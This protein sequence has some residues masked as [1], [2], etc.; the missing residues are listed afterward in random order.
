MQSQGLDDVPTPR[1]DF[2]HTHGPRAEDG[3]QRKCVSQMKAAARSTTTPIPQVYSEMA[4]QL[5]AEDLVAAS[6]LLPEASLS[7]S[8][9]RARRQQ[10]PALPQSLQD[11]Q[12][13]PDVFS[14]L[15][16]GE[17]RFLL[18][19]TLADN[20]GHLLFATD[21]ALRWL[22]E[23]N[24]WHMDGT[25]KSAPRLF[26]QLFTIQVVRGN[27]T[28]PCIYGLLPTK[29]KRCYKN[30]LR[31]VKDAVAERHLPL[32]PTSIMVDFEVGLI[33]AIQDEFPNAD[34][35]GCL[36]HFSQAVWRHI[37][38]LGLTQ[39]YKADGEFKS[40]CRQL[41]AL[42]FLPEGDV[43][44]AY[45]FIEQ[46]AID[47]DIDD[48]DDLFAYYQEQWMTG[49]ISIATWNC[50]G[51]DIR[52]NNAVE[53]FHHRFNRVIG[54]NHPNTWI[55]IERLQQEE[56]RTQHII[57]QMDQGLRLRSGRRRYTQINERI[58]LLEQRRANEELD[59]YDFLV[60][61]GNLLHF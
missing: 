10:Y 21:E 57:S 61:V 44:Q 56:K 26:V 34:A 16:G 17:E 31:I 3:L 25:F 37:Q 32:Q 42:P 19:N 50:H 2:E 36:F 18:S 7:A 23:A 20:N 59:V 8:L 54:R 40:V 12:V 6:M 1:G 9:Y 53:G 4:S 49:T 60:A 33:N 5:Q 52:T 35:K 45:A 22:S 11:L 28:I 55:L 38:H 14:N 47:N 48:I 51:R 43:E 39:R 13:I 27:K 29:R 15:G 24:H 30:V 58:A 46:T 41:M